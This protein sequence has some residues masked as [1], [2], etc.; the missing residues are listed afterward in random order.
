MKKFFL[1]IIAALGIAAT[2]S[3]ISPELQLGYG[4]YTQMDATD[5]HDGGK[6]NNAWG[7]I[8]AGIN[9]HVMPK[10]DLGVSYTF[11]SA[12]F[13]HS[14]HTAYY[15]VIMLNG[16]YQ[17]FR[18]SIVKLYAHLGIGADITHF[19]YT[20]DNKGYFAFQIAPIGAQVDLS[21]NFAMYGE[22]GF[23]AQG[24]LQVGV[25]YKF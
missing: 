24:L 2:A 17:Y 22:L 10:F 1:T 15:H 25:R 20:D 14:D 21:R 12:D 5:M 19:S 11:S 16:R 6:I 7:A 13:K 18:N 4:G 9:F 3:A 8:T 23:G